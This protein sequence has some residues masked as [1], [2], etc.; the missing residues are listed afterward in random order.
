LATWYR[1]GV[2]VLLT[3][4]MLAVLLTGGRHTQVLEQLRN[5]RWTPFLAAS[6]LYAAAQIVSSWRWQWLARP[7]GLEVRLGRLVQLYFV[8]M[9]FNLF[10]PTSMGGDAV[11]SWYLARLQ[12]NITF[13]T[14]LASVVSER[15]NG[16]I[17]LLWLG[18]LAS[19][20]AMNVLPAW[21]V[22]CMSSLGVGATVFLAALPVL[23]RF[24]RCQRWADA[25]SL[26]ARSRR[27]WLEALGL[28]LLVQAAAIAQVGLVARALGL[29]VAWHHLAVAVPIT[30][31]ASLLPIS[32]AGLGL[33]EGSLALLLAPAGLSTAQ[34]VSLGLG[35]LAMQGLTSLLGA[36]L[37]WLLPVGNPTV[38]C[39]ADDSAPTRSTAETPATSQPDRYAV[40][41]NAA[42]PGADD[43][44]E[45]SHGCLGGHSDQG[46]ARQSAAAA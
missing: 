9:F 4:I 3:T 17:A 5:L 26:S 10:L 37:W 35:W 46:R 2:R 41:V 7:L 1:L 12:G 22:A 43:R 11:R 36:P 31:V 16:L 13:G 19:L 28:S 32:I 24:P 45:A 6:L 38:A 44:G 8:G 33:R 14:A 21:Q 40:P 42:L 20:V 25:L 30:T 27:T 15:L 34:S 29:S 23:G 18:C 39:S